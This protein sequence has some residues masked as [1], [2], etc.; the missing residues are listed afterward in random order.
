MRKIF[1]LC[2]IF[3]VTI[4]AC[5]SDDD[6]SAA[7]NSAELDGTWNAEDLSIV[8]NAVV[9]FQGQVIETNS[10]AV[11]YDTDYVITFNETTN[12][13][14]STGSYDL[15]DTTV[16]LGQTIIED[17]QDFEFLEN[18]TWTQDG[19]VLRISFEDENVIFEINELTDSALTIT[20]NESE[21]IVEDGESYTITT[22]I[23]ATFRR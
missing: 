23:I 2:L 8:I 20:L 22:E 3:T 11:S 7:N 15:E 18:G 14:V 5:S 17:I 1:I 10:T 12:T 6:S 16:A 13:Y 21:T 19:T 9:N 4:V